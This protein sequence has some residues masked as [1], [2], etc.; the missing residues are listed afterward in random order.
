VVALSGLTS[1]GL[2]VVVNFV[3]ES[4]FRWLLLVFALPWAAALPLYALRR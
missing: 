3:I 2:M 4:D 1:I